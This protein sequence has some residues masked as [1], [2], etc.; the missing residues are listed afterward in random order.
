M[1]T[2]PYAYPSIDSG[3]V[4]CPLRFMLRDYHSVFSNVV[5]VAYSCG[6][7][8]SA[9]SRSLRSNHGAELH[10]AK[11]DLTGQLQLTIGT[12]HRP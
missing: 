4:D 9:V 11:S 6:C 12:D 2:T 5:I 7:L 1:F 8:I 3:F 10:G